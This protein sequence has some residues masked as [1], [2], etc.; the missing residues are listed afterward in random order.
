MNNAINPLAVWHEVVETGNVGLLA[1]IL[2]DDVVFISPV[3]HTHQKGKAITQ[4][5]LSA[6]AKVFNSGD[7]KYVREYLDDTGAIMEFETQVDG[8]YV[9]GVDMLRWNEAG[10]LTEFKV[11]LRPLQAV[12]LLH[13]KM[14][15]ML[16][17]LKV[18]PG[19]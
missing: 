14:G 8:V 2:S 16:M 9:N 11:M 18:K 19:P 4:L 10:L 17:A 6:A 5:Y 1:D 13:Q 7:F 3:V 15:E 12:N